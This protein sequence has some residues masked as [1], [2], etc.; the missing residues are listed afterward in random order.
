MALFALAGCAEHHYRAYD[1]YHSDY[2]VWNDT[3]GQLSITVIPIAIF[4]GCRPT[5]KR[6]TG[7]G[8]IANPNDAAMVACASSCEVT[9]SPHLIF[10]ECGVKG[11]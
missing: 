8:G 11:S 3:G 10:Q 9:K 5:N 2:H 6:N 7:I 4:D 1:P